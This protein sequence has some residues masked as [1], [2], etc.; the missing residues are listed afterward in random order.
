[1]DADER[2]AVRYSV[3][4]APMH[5]GLLFL[6]WPFVVR[7][8]TLPRRRRLVERVA[9]AVALVL[10]A[11]QVASGQAAAATTRAMRATLDR[12]AAGEESPDMTSVV[13]VNLAQARRDPDVIRGAGLYL[14]A[15]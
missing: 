5:V 12:F 14:D 2:V 4:V 7:Q 15:R 13:F 3:L 10:L 6:V 11:Q 9:V 8:W 1:M